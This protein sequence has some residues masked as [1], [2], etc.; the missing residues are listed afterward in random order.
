MENARSLEA[1]VAR[2]EARNSRVEA[3]KA[4]ETSFF[5]HALITIGTYVF[6]ALFLMTINASNPLLSALVP[7]AAFVFSTLSLPPLKEWWLGRRRA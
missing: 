4:W 3:D 7:A 5:R 6:S 2:I 1:R